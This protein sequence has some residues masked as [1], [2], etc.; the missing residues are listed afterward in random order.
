MP[1]NQRVLRST[2]AKTISAVLPPVILPIQSATSSSHSEI[3][4]LAPGATL[5]DLDSTELSLLRKKQRQLQS[6][7]SATL[8][9]LL[10]RKHL[11]T[12]LE[13]SLIFAQHEAGT[14]VC[15]DAAGWVLTCSHCFGDTEEEWRAKK[16]KWLLFYTGRAVQVECRA[17]D[18]MRDLAL[19]K[20]IAIESGASQETANPDTVFNFVPLSAS[21]PSIKTLI[22]CVGQPGSD[23]LESTTDRR[24]NY[25]LIEVSEGKFCGMIPGADPDNNSVIGSLKHNA[26]TYWGHSGAPLLKAVDGTLIGLHSSWD[27]KTAMR[28]GVPLIAIKHF[29]QQQVDADIFPPNLVNATLVDLNSLQKRT[30]K[31]IAFDAASAS[32]PKKRNKCTVG[33]FRAPILIDD[34]V[35]IGD[36]NE[37]EVCL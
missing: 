10:L 9:S 25:E 37:S 31:G 29:L 24:T 30:M 13:A 5:P 16:R 20:I 14:A 33:N 6:S 34:S 7:A 4:I 35:I 1:D 18:S 28:H 22:V 12:A 36:K 3:R 32:L 8:S 27:D 15:I 2:L 21:A 19:L 17:W 11:R 26:W 23:D